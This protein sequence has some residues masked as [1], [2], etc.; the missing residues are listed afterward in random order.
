MRHSYRPLKYVLV[1][2]FLGGVALSLVN[3]CTLSS[4][5][6]EGC[7]LQPVWNFV[8]AHYLALLLLLLVT[9][10]LLFLAWRADRKHKAL[11]SFGLVKPAAKL[12]PEDLGF[13]M[14]ESGKIPTQDRRPY[15][16]NSYISRTVVLYDRRNVEDPQPRY[17]EDDLV[18]FLREGSGFILLGQPLDGKSHT[19]YEVVKR[20]EGYQVLKPHRYRPV[21]DDNAFALVLKG[22]KVILLLDDLTEYSESTV[23]VLLFGQRLGHHA[24]SWTVAS[25]CR[26]GPELGRVREAIGHG[27]KRFYDD[28]PR[29]MALLPPTLEN[30]KRIAERIGRKWNHSQGEQYPNPG[31]IV[32]A[33]PMRYM[34]E[35]FQDLSLRHP[36]QRDVLRALKLLDHAGILPLTHIRTCAVLEHIFHRNPT[37]LGDCLDALSD[38]AFLRP[39]SLDP[40][41]PEPAYLV[42]VVTYREGKS[43]EEDYEQLADVFEDLGDYEALFYLASAVSYD[44]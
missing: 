24:S 32:M 38:K 44:Q 7:E 8:R 21:P 36:E 16:Q 17:D 39:G 9:I 4:L 33:E 18:Q 40:I 20:M 34:K 19:L 35:R 26:D 43:E 28:I 23:N 6:G 27:L 12:I 5:R 30:K 2:F 11:D 31:S 25:T 10:V 13:Q 14:L 29:K 3:N 42:N 22:R 15:H 37:H 41:Q 1:T